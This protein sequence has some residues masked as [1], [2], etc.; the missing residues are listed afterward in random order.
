MA[1]P[2]LPPHTSALFSAAEIRA[3]RTVALLRIV[4]A[5]A[6]GSVFLLAIPTL[7]PSELSTGILFRQWSYAGGTLLAYLLLGLASFEAIKRG[8]YRPWMAWL[9]VTGDCAFIAGSLWLSLMN[10]GMQADFMIGLPSI[11]LVPVVLAFG[12]LRFNPLLQAY[13]IALLVAG[14]AAVYLL[15]PEQ[16]D[17]P[18]P[19]VLN[20][21]FQLPPNLMRLAMLG[22]AGM[23]LVVASSHARALLAR[24]IGES[25]RRV[26]L[27]RYL[28]SQIA[29][30]MADA[31]LDAL[32]RGRQQNAA[33][34][35][36]DIR[37]FTQMSEAM[38]PEATGAF[39]SE[40][41]ARVSRAADATG[42][43]IDKFIG[44]AAM[45]VFGLVDPADGDAA[46]ALDCADR[47]L[48]DMAAWNRQRR[49]GGLEPVE[50]GIGVHWGG[51][52]AGAI[53]D[54]SRLEYTVLG[55]TVNV[56]ARLEELTKSAGWPLITSK[57]TLAAA[58]EKVRWQDWQAL[59]SE[60]LRGRHDPTE[61][62]GSRGPATSG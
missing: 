54:E 47:I 59:E 24:A 46:A 36:V 27:T 41:R 29:D 40:F 18:P 33:V 58:G 4:I 8:R 57:E 39:L 48:C 19:A 17:P 35:F 28:P 12:A 14:L 53:G 20:L 55:D 10:T 44:D 23:I 16:A 31:G 43:T 9:V 52:F 56:A 49:T 22:L 50:V 7:T 32:S 11:W 3:E 60:P 2:S 51:L 61:I 26:N 38:T 42:G 25:Q 34:L 45:V 1:Y 6:L 37:Q 13:L 30:T 21:F 5:L 62:Y 15:A